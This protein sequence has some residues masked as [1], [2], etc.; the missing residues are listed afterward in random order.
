MSC[1]PEKNEIRDSVLSMLQVNM[2]LTAGESLLVLTDLPGPLDWL[3][4]PVGELQRMLERA[5]LARQ[6]VEIA[7]EHFR[8]NL[9][10]FYPFPATG[11]DGVE[12][13]ETTA[14]RML[15]AD[16]ILGLT[17]YSL[18]HTDARSNAC[19]HG[20][21]VASMPL[22]EARM[23]EPDGPLAVDSAQVSAD[24]HR[25]AARLTTARQVVVRT[26]DGTELAFSIEGRPGQVD[27]GIYA[28]APGKWGNLPAGEA[29]VVP[30]EGSGQGKLVVRAG[31]YP[32]LD[33]E[34]IFEVKDGQVVGLNGGGAV[35]DKFRRLLK[36]GDDE[37]VYRARRNLAE[38]GIG[39]NPNARQPD[40]VLEAEKIKGTVHIAFGDNLHM[41]GKVDSDFH[42]DFV[43]PEVDM[44]LDEERVIS[45]GEWQI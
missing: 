24:A 34:M 25:F 2:G 29:Y 38:L 37:P 4:K 17:T 26:P 16:V 14:T 36:T 3:N 1:W 33:K 42:E 43:L 35:G 23:L 21:R 40:N 45:K 39:C 9:V 32:M 44:Y 19:Q 27:D 6:I 12:L 5:M 18:S 31:W 20:A 15:S 7:A 41:G 22:F 8:E 10:S 13:D 28:G 11:G 30:V